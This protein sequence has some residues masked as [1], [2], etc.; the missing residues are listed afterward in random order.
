MMSLISAEDLVASMKRPTSFCRSSGVETMALGE[1][2][3]SGS[4]SGSESDGESCVPAAV[5]VLAAAAASSCSSG[6][7][8]RL[9][10]LNSLI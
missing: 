8:T 3:C 9:N 1:C 7:A 2:C 6:S 5:E 10:S 4:I